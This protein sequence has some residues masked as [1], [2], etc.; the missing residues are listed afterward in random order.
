MY[1]VVVFLFVL[2]GV[3]L[4]LNGLAWL[5]FRIRPTLLLTENERLQIDLFSRYDGELAAYRAEWYGLREEEWSDFVAE[6]L[7]FGATTIRHEAFTG[8]KLAAYSGKYYNMSPDGY[9]KLPSQGEW[10]PDEQC[11]NIFFFGGSTAFNQGPDWTSIPGYLQDALDGKQDRP[12]RVYNFGR[13]AYFSTQDMI[14][15][16]RLLSK[17]IRP[18]V[19]VF[20]HGLNDFFFYDDNPSTYGTFS[21]LYEDFQK[22]H[23]AEFHG[24]RGAVP[25]WHSLTCFITSLP[26]SRALDIAARRMVAGEDEKAPAYW[27]DDV[28]EDALLAVIRRYR[29]N[30]KEIELLASEYGVQPIFLWQPV[31]GYRYNLAHHLALQPHYGLGGHGRS[32]TG[33]RLMERQLAEQPEGDHFIWLADMQ[34]KLERPLYVDNVHYTA[35]FS[36]LIAEQAAEEIMRRRLLPVASP[37]PGTAAVVSP[38]A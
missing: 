14:L 11:L 15:F 7:H 34:E 4:G 38:V 17:G 10:P 20:L 1:S 19:A 37:K 5:V 35:E 29:H 36:R 23:W 24:R 2:I 28:S 12:V 30:K 25:D 26:L 27:S 18:D 22:R 8:H 31:P 3:F 21:N 16:S 9:R 6:T 33:Y 13:P 32:G